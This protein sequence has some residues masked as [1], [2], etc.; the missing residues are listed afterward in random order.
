[1]N[2]Y[3]WMSVSLAV[4]LYLYLARQIRKGSAEQNL[5]TFISWGLLDTVA[6]VSLYVQHGNWYLLLA[7]VAGCALIVGCII[8]SAKFTWG[9]VEIVC[10]AMVVVSI[11]IWKLSS[12]AY[13]TIIST[14]GVAIACY[15]QIKDAILKPK[16]AP[17]DVYVGFVIVNALSTAGGKAWTIDERLYPGVCTV[18]CILI[19]GFASRKYFNR[20][21]PLS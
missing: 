17:A 11:V 5:A 1:M 7:Y 8:S 2:I 18:L 15:P 14:A 21:H 9:W 16:T 6:G 13:A 4:I 12:P 10:F 3:N 19:V 20:P